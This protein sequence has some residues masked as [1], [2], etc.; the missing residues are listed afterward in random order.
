MWRAQLEPIEASPGI[1]QNA[2]MSDPHVTGV[3]AVIFFAA[4]LEATVNFY[5]AIGVALEIEDHG[6][7]HR[8]HAADVGGI[9]LAIFEGGEARPETGRR[10]GGDFVGLTVSSLTNSL[11]AARQLGAEVAEEPTD[12]HWGTRAIVVD[13]DGRSVE[14]IEVP[15]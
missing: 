5:R 14:M 1:D 10:N 13:P 15:R 6:D 9:H 7:G 12:Y 4:D 2:Q 3:G 11:E 8:H